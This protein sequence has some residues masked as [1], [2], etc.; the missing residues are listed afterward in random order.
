M[1]KQ[2]S[3]IEKKFIDKFYFFINKPQTERIFYY[4]MQNQRILSEVVMKNQYTKFL[5]KGL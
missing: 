1:S 4:F 5:L 3:S 2:N